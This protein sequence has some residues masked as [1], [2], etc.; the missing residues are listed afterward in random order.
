MGKCRGFAS[1]F[2]YVRQK[3]KHLPAP[4]RMS[5]E[6][7]ERSIAQNPA[8]RAD[9]WGSGGNGPL[10][11]SACLL[12]GRGKGSQV[13]RKAHSSNWSSSP[14]VGSRDC[15]GVDWATTPQHLPLQWGRPG[16]PAVFVGDVASWG[17]TAADFFLSASSSQKVTGAGSGEEPIKRKVGRKRGSEVP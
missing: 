17:S 14:K 2:Q 3:T 7:Q 5:S 1:Q 8:G 12:R 4:L 10:L 16:L 11:S 15:G 13:L 6:P 9:S